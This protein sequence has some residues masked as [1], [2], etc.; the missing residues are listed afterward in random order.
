MSGPLLHA[1]ADCWHLKA[2]AEVSIG[3]VVNTPDGA[4]AEITIACAQCGTPFRFAGGMILSQG[5][6]KLIAPVVAHVSDAESAPCGCDHCADRRLVE[7][8]EVKL[9]RFGV[10]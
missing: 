1:S 6:L 4:I 9:R 10:D 7:S 3:R 8:A 2:L 5:G